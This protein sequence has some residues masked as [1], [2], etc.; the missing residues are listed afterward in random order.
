MQQLEQLLSRFKA[1]EGDWSQKDFARLADEL[2]STSAAIKDETKTTEQVSHAAVAWLRDGALSAQVSATLQQ[3]ISHAV[4]N[5]QPFVD[6]KDA[7]KI[8]GIEELHKWKREK[9]DNAF[10]RYIHR[11]LLSL[12]TKTGFKAN[13][14]EEFVYRDLHYLTTKY[15]ELLGSVDFNGYLQSVINQRLNLGTNGPF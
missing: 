4:Q 6:A 8:A 5:M 3:D 11:Y 12:R 15:L 13:H 1:I 14:L 7:S 9:F 2:T 10:G